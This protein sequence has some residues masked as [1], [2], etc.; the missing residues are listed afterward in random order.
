MALAR[1]GHHAQAEALI[2]GSGYGSGRRDAQAR[3]R[4]AAALARA[5]A[6]DAAGRVAATIRSPSI[7]AQ[8]L[9]DVLAAA[10][11][12]RNSSASWMLLP[13]LR[14]TVWR[15][16]DPGAACDLVLPLAAA[17][18][19]KDLHDQ[20]TEVIRLADEL[21]DLV[22][23]RDDWVR[24]R[25]AVILAARGDWPASTAA[26]QQLHRSDHIARTIRDIASLADAA[27]E[28]DRAE[29]MIATMPDIRRRAELLT[30]VAR[31][32]AARG[33]RRR[34]ADLATA[35]ERAARSIGDHNRLAQIADHVVD[36][37]NVTLDALDDATTLAERVPEPDRRESA[38]GRITTAWAAI[39]RVDHARA[40]ADRLE[41]SRRIWAL[42]NIAHH[43]AIAGDTETTPALIDEALSMIGAIPDG[44][45]RTTVLIRLARALPRVGSGNEAPA[46]LH[47]AAAEADT[48]S[49]LDRRSRALALLAVAARE[50]E[51][52]D[53]SAELERRADEILDEMNPPARSRAHTRLAEDF[54]ETGP[55]SMAEQHRQHVTSPAGRLRATCA[56]AAAPGIESARAA[57]CSAKRCPSSRPS[58]RLPTE[59][60]L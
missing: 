16:V 4:V 17:L 18:T 55:L 7:C 28:H 21:L 12:A 51:L 31:A 57:R 44:F 39:G 24:G 41:P 37:A 8:A 25:K 20:A 48:L 40:L 11:D 59:A 38:L 27:G 26:L 58:T 34:A 46:L 1:F 35:A 32:A 30:A 60:R 13:E 42:G 50:L 6:I 15:A 33:D 56:I 2:A 5:G 10:A 53:W 14:T 9:T 45:S 23:G 19:S 49:D 3:G 22:D 47:R 52:H 43:L 29:P 36:G 54:A